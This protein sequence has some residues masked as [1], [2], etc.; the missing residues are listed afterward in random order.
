MHKSIIII[1]CVILLTYSNSFSNAFV[2]DDNLTILDNNFITSWS[3]FPRLFEKSYITTIDQ[4][5]SDRQQSYK[6]LDKGSGEIT[7]RPV[8]TLT[9]MID[10]FFWKLNPLGYHISNIML[11][12]LN[13]ILLYLFIL[14]LAK[15]NLVAL[16]TS[17]FFCAHPINTSVVNHISFREDLLAVFFFLSAFILFIKYKKYQGVKKIFLYCI[18]C[19]SFFLAVF[20]KEMAITF[21]LMIVLYD[22]YFKPHMN[23]KKV[24]VDLKSKYLG[25][26]LVSVF[27][28]IVYFFV[29]PNPGQTQTP[30]IVNMNDTVFAIISTLRFIGDY[31]TY[32]VLPFGVTFLPLRYDL[33]VHSIFQW[34]IVCSALLIVLSIIMGIKA[35]KYSKYISFG[36]FWLYITLL[37]TVNLIPIFN[38]KAFRY[39]YLPSIGFC[40][41]LAFVFES[42]YKIKKIRVSS[43]HLPKILAT[44]IV[45]TYIFLALPQ[46]L[47]W[48][49]DFILSA[50]VLYH[51]PYDVDALL[52]QA[53]AYVKGGRFNNAVMN[54]KA[55]L[56]LEPM[57]ASIHNSIGFC[58]SSMSQY[59]KAVKEFNKSIELDSGF[60]FPHINLG[61]MY[62][63]RKKYNKAIEYFEDALDLDD[64]AIDAYTGLALVY[65]ELNRLKKAKAMTYKALEVFPD[66]ESAK[67]ILKT[68]EETEK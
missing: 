65:I 47:F 20:S 7:Y 63:D 64:K 14:L 19:L 39:L 51:D 3:N 57:S 56:K 44:I 45:G 35:Y 5:I 15:S 36:I 21:P 38:P 1:I 59:D 50:E 68:I 26:I 2:A 48:K 34:D 32:F 49:N 46:N 17:L 33:L 12:I 9:Y 27:Y 28:L 22:F 37:P 4:L 53:D 29:L 67:E 31:I 6:A 18:S 16:F 42:L 58:Y 23:I 55:A 24:F 52:V 43:P 40:I 11:H 8:V 62:A 54:Y 60:V 61:F 13:S 10:Y 66:H 25:Y 41:M 30:H